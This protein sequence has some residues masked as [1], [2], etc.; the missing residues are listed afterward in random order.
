M[1]LR[2]STLTLLKRRIGHS[3]TLFK[4][5]RANFMTL[6]HFVSHRELTN[7]SNIMELDFLIFFF[8]G[9]K[10]MKTAHR[11]HSSSFIGFGFKK[12]PCSRC[13]I[14]KL[15]TQCKTQ[16]SEINNPFS[17]ICHQEEIMGVPPPPLTSKDT[18]KCLN[19][20]Q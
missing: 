3:A 20:S 15:Y 12:T 1:P 8:W 14:V 5:K 2:P 17:S 7:F 6:I 18:S 13:L 10:I 16:D 11:Q 19:I 4:D 9:I